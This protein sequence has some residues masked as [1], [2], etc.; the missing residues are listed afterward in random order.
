M[1]ISSANEHSNA[2]Q[3]TLKSYL[4][5]GLPVDHA[6]DDAQAVGGDVADGA[7]P[8]QIAGAVALGEPVEPVDDQHNAATLSGCD[9]SRRAHSLPARAPISVPT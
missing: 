2:R 7:Q 8:R 9:G 6:D 3:M 1:G 4:R 5:R